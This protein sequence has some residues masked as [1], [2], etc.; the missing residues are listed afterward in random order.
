MAKKLCQGDEHAEH[1]V[2]EERDEDV[3]VDLGEDPGRH[4]DVRHLDV[5]VVHVVAVDY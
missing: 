3:E 5:G 4:G 1:D 2:D